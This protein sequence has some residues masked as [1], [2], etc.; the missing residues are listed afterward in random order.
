MYGHC[1]LC[2]INPRFY[3]RQGFI[4]TYGVRMDK[5]SSLDLE[6]PPGLHIQ[7][8][9]TTLSLLPMFHYE[10]LSQVLENAAIYMPILAGN[11]IPTSR[12]HKTETS[13]ISSAK[14]REMFN[15]N[16]GV[17]HLITPQ[18]ESLTKNI[19]PL[20]ASNNIDSIFRIPQY[21]ALIGVDKKISLQIWPTS[22]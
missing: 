10:M 17:V 22:Y 16:L 20:D 14:L 13:F 15:G 18:Y 12:R 19:R 3:I 7:R 21:L 8:Q 5:S 4:N 9:L 1:P 6:L 2:S 11:V